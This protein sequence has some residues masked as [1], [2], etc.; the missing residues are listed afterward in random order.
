MASSNPLVLNQILAKFPHKHVRMAFA[1]G[2]AVLTQSN[3]ATKIQNQNTLANASITS[4]STTS[5]PSMID[6]VF[7]VDDPVRFHAE[8]M[9]AHPSHY[10][11]LRH[12]GPYYLSRFQE[13]LGA[14]CYYNTLIPIETDHPA[15]ASHL[16]K[17]GVI[18]EE[19]LIRDLYDWDYIYV[20]GRL[21][22]PVR[23]L[24]MPSVVESLQREQQ[25]QQQQQFTNSQAKKKKSS[26]LASAK[27]SDV[28]DHEEDDDDDSVF[29][30]DSVDKSLDLALQ[31]NLKNALHTALLLLPA[32]FT[33]DELF[34]TIV[35]LSYTGDLRMLVGEDKRK[36]RNI[37]EPQVERFTRLYKPHIVKECLDG[38]LACDF[39]TG[40]LEQAAGV[41]S[42]VERRLNFLPKNLIQTIVNSNYATRHCYDLE[43]Y[44]SKLAMRVDYAQLIARALATIVRRTSTVQALKGFL[45]AGV[46]KTLVY[47]SR[48]LGKM[49]KSTP[50]K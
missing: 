26:T 46:L 7:V 13:R 14:A 19:A 8:N 20:S 25:Q 31:T 50:P 45:S 16:I 21:Q 10:S 28:D 2:S 29:A 9:R 43:E 12:I 35:E 4:K 49:I 47:S 40:R 44:V 42:S 38:H 5:P 23:I 24:K 17:Y 36:C 3:N 6:F 48:K 39:D 41:V 33:L 27:S 32:R 37:V 1:Y 11:M 18:S 30:C 15:R 22:K 34:V